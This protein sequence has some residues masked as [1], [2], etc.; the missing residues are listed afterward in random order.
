MATLQKIRNQAGLLV[1]VIGVALLAFI[2]G[3]FLNSGNTFF[4]MSQNKVAEV[5]GEKITV[6]EFQ[7]RVNQAVE[8]E[9]MRYRRDY[10]T[11]MPDGRAAQ[12]NKEVFDRMVSTMVLTDVAK[13]LGIAVSPA[14]M[15][16]LLKGDNISP[17]V[18]SLFGNPQTGEIDKTALNSFLQQIFADDLSS[19]SEE[20]QQMVAEQR[21]M[22]IELEKAVKEER[23]MSKLFTLIHKS[24]QPNDVDLEA[25]F[26]ESSK[27]VD[28]AYVA[29]LYTAIPDSLVSVSEKEIKDRYAEKRENFKTDETRSIDFVE[30][31]IVPSQ[32]DYKATEEK[33]NSFKEQFATTNDVA[34]LLSFNTDVPYSDIF[35]T[36][37]K[38]DENMKG[39]VKEAKIDDVYGPAFEN[40]SYKMYRLMAKS[41][42]PDSVEVRHIMF[43]ANQE[44]LRDSI[45][46]VIKKGGN[47]AELAKEY[48]MDTNTASEGGNFG[49]L[50]EP[51]CV[52]LGKEFIEA[53]FRGGKGVQKIRT[54]FG[55]H[56]LEVTNQT[57][58][59]E[60]AKVAQFVMNVRP[61]SETYSALYNK[62]S[63]Y[64]AE[65]NAADNFTAG[66]TE[67]GIMVQNTTLTKDDI[68]ISN[69]RDAREIVRWAF[70]AD[71]DELSDI[72]NVDNKFVVVKVAKVNEAG[73]APLAEVE[74]ML[75]A[76]LLAEKKGDK[77]VELLKGVESIE[78]AAEKLSAKV[79]TAKSV[80]FTS[81]VVPGIGM[82]PKLSGAAPFAEKYKVQGPVKGN[83][84]VYVYSVAN[85]NPVI[86][87]FNKENEVARYNQIIQQMMYRQLVNVMQSQAEVEDNRIK[88]F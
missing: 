31:S 58:P 55:I 3:D 11:T 45:Y 43:G 48:S 10:N 54:N 7:A 74:G 4:Q 13:E 26:A 77:V 36:V 2:I 18:V 73:Y 1:I 30:V 51:M 53:A 65:S 32:A 76:Q 75:K 60:K 29:Q 63:Q 88:F 41:N 28:I 81:A 8:Q 82:E 61:S 59:V 24:V 6:E 44:A 49:W 84:A 20:Q 67:K 17:Q 68:N 38:M 40:N 9:Q 83:R 46:D 19:M 78:A 70:N 34:G 27:N 39:F 5:N 50:T 37:S 80:V 71:E 72:F 47:F 52:Q 16:D 21:A 25:A 66:D 64:I 86:S 42:C 79:D 33:I 57:K 56:L 12:I 69:I 62:V 35:T 22:W 23:V 85:D 15:S 14:E 87:T